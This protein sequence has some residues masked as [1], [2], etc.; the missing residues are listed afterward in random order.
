MTIRQTADRPTAVWHA[1]VWARFFAPARPDFGL[2]P[3]SATGVY[4]EWLI[5]AWDLARSLKHAVRTGAYRKS[6]LAGLRSLRQLRLRHPSDMFHV[7]KRLRVLGALRTA[8]Y[9]TTIRIDNVQ[10]GLVAIHRILDLWPGA[11]FRA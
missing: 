7:S 5:E 1:A 6:I 8:T 10:H 9:A 11:E 2:P 3:A 4:L